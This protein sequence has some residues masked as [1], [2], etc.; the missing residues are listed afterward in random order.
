MGI[1]LG[2]DGS[3]MWFT[4]GQAGSA[5]GSITTAGVITYS[6]AAGISPGVAAARI[7][8]TFS[9]AEGYATVIPSGALNNK[10]CAF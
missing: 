5:Y 1:A 6:N 7:G 3:T 2:T 10:G 9:R 4:G 8:A